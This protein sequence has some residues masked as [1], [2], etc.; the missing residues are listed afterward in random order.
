MLG[1]IALLW[2]PVRGILIQVWTKGV[3]PRN[4]LPWLVILF[5]RCFRVALSTSVA[6][7]VIWLACTLLRRGVFKLDVLVARLNGSRLRILVP[8]GPHRCGLGSL[9]L[10][11]IFTLD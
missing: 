1:L 8:Y 10:R 7:T 5:V 9:S 6:R 11:I 4:L 2:N 3:Y